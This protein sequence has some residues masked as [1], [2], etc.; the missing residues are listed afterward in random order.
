MTMPGYKTRQRKNYRLE[1][2]RELQLGRPLVGLRGSGLV[3][4]LFGQLGQRPPGIAVQRE[5]TPK[6]SPLLMFSSVMET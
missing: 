6:G 2:D 3:L 4:A 1:I 5:Y